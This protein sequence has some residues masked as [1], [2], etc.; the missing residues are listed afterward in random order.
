MCVCMG[1]FAHSQKYLAPLSSTWSVVIF[2]CWFLLFPYKQQNFQLAHGG[3][4]R[5]PFHISAL[6]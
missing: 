2:I 3:W 5:L 1:G 6:H 4:T